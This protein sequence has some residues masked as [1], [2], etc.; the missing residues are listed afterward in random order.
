[1]T[2]IHLKNAALFDAAST[3]LLEGRAVLVEDGRVVEVSDGPIKANA[4]HTIDLAGRALLPGLI[5]AHVHVNS[6]EV[7]FANLE[8]LPE[9]LITAKARPMME[10]M[11]M[12]GFTTVRD[13]GGPSFAL[14][15]AIEHHEWI[16]VTAWSP[17]WMWERF[18]L[19]YLKDPKNVLGTE[20]HVDV[21]ANP[22]LKKNEP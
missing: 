19:R 14:K 22:S 11:L 1:M 8:R 3:E 5:D 15:R 13:V 21:I 10:A 2:I 4:D 16:V 18:N 6:V 17:H 12:R 7:G 20:D 9:S